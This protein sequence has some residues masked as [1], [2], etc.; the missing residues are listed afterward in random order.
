MSWLG[1]LGRGLVRTLAP[2]GI[3]PG[4]LVLVVGPSGGGKDTLIGEARRMCRDD[5]VVFP[6]RVVTRPASTAEDNDTVSDVAFNAAVAEGAFAIWWHAHG[7]KYG[8]PLSID[9]DIRAGRTVVCNASRTIVGAA[10]DRYMHVTVVLVTAPPEVLSARLAQRGRASDGSI[11]DR[12]RRAVDD[13]LVPDVTIRNVGTIE[14][15]A[16]RLRDVLL[17]RHAGT[18]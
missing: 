5:Q 16:E 12:L 15:N 4:R 17:G 1:E 9:S 13:G 14:A 6:R 18:L 11:E 10:R 7:L 2:H 8:I 3:G